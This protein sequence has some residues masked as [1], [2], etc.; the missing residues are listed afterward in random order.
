MRGS[1]EGGGCF[2]T[3][4]HYP[5]IAHLLSV[6]VE[7]LAAGFEAGAAVADLRWVSV[8]TETTGRE[9]SVDRVVEIGCVIF[10]RGQVVESRGWLVD[11]E[12]PIP[13]EA[14]NVHGILDADVHGKPKFAE[15]LPEL[16]EFVRGAVPLAYNAEFDRGFLHAEFARTGVSLPNLPPLFDPDVR[17]LDP[18]TF[19]R[20][21]QKNERSRALGEVCERLGIPLENAHRA[22]DDATA[23]GRV[24]AAF[25]SDPRVPPT[26]GALL[27]EQLRLDRLFELTRF[28]RG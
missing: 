14:S 8:D 4:R 24:M 21:I 25:L 20:E 28:R 6:T 13:E 23:A 15:V 3:G 5:G 27:K 17:W 7:G 22:T 16:V 11:P 26:Y 18:L 1:M 12:C 10:E 9:A 2:P 19:A